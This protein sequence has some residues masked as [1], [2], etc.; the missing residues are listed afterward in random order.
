MFFFRDHMITIRWIQAGASPNLEPQSVSVAWGPYFYSIKLSR[1]R[2]TAILASS[3]PGR[4]H[5]PRGTAEHETRSSAQGNCSAKSLAAS[6]MSLIIPCSS[7]LP[8]PP[9]PPPVMLS[10]GG[11]IW[12]VW[13]QGGSMGGRG[14]F[15]PAA[16]YCTTTWCF[17]L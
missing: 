7:I 1:F 13:P 11:S 12:G 16:I 5:G 10:T 17:A 4:T 2:G 15:G 14:H 3:L 8:C 9:C 6:V